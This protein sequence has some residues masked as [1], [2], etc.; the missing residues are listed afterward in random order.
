[1]TSELIRYSFLIILT[2]ISLIFLYVL[3]L[4][5]RAENQTKIHIPIL[6]EIIIMINIIL[7]IFSFLFVFAT[8]L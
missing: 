7:I 2:M 5:K 8:K 3:Y 1:M 6:G 4:I